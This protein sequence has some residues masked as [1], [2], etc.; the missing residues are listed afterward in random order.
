MWTWTC[1]G[2]REVF[3]GATKAEAQGKFFA[4]AN[5]AHPKATVLSVAPD[6]SET[7]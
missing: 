7:E 6:E 5:E 4:H 2:C 3:N 1:T